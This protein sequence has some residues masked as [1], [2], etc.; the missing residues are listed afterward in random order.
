MS[1]A[2]RR[3]IG[4]IVLILVPVAVFAAMVLA[5]RTFGAVGRGFGYVVSVD[6]PRPPSEPGLPKI[7][8]SQD[9]G[10]PL[11]VIDAGH[12]GKDPGAG[13]G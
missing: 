1:F 3:I 6:V 12:G 13:G 8:G 11:V 2:M 10:R 4:I 9:G 5:D 7:E